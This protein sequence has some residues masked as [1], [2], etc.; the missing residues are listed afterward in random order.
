MIRVDGSIRSMKGSPT[1]SVGDIKL[2]VDL[3]LAKHGSAEFDKQRQFDAAITDKNGNRVRA[4]IYQ[5][6]GLSAIVMR[7]IACDIPTPGELGL[8]ADI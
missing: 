7:I 1:L 3:M 4:N 2:M 8:P 6:M 5:Q